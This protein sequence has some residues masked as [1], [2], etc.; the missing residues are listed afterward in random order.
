MKKL[1]K[2]IRELS[3]ADATLIVVVVVGYLVAVIASAEELTMAE[4]M[5]TF[6]MAAVYLGLARGADP[7]FERFPSGWAKFIYFAIQLSL[8]AFITYILGPNAWLIPLPLA[9]IAVG[10]L[11]K[12]WQRGFVYLGIILTLTLPIA[13]TGQWAAAFLFSLTLIPAILFIVVFSRLVESEHQAREDAEALA[14]ELEEANRRLSAYSTQ[15]EELA[16]TR[17]RNRLARE[18]H[19]NLG[20]YLT[21]V[22]VQ[23]RA[24]QTVM[25]SDPEKA[26]DALAN[27]QRLTQEGLDAVRRSVAALRESPLGGRSLA[28]AIHFLVQEAQVGGLVIECTVRGETAELDPKVE[29]TL[30]RTVQEGLTNIRKHAHASRAG[31]I[32]D[33]GPLSGAEL[34]IS[35]NGVGMN[36]SG[37]EGFGLLGIKERVDHLGGQLLIE[38]KP[39]AGFTLCVSL[40]PRAADLASHAGDSEDG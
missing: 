17:E 9:A 31:V 33:V 5:V 28:D 23:I 7:L 34:T 32:L 24:A 3:A 15:V 26:Q 6:V 37:V 30:Y 1:W 36:T 18:I 11:D 40:P 2:L 8:I 25:A 39:G 14:A 29:L 22:N 20:H 38:S 12:W 16:R 19:D 13:L 35:D 4:I 27:A 10:H 21:V